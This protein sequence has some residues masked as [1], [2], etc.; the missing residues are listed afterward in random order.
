MLEKLNNFCLKKGKV[1]E[2]QGLGVEQMN[3]TVR[4]WL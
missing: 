2:G 4:H 3:R 1:I